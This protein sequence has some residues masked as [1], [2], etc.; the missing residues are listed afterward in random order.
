M[1]KLQRGGVRGS[2]P[3]EDHDEAEHRRCSLGRGA[4]P[5]PVPVGWGARRPFAIMRR[6][7]HVTGVL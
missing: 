7:A 3:T 4:D 5:E 6:L 1:G 2:A